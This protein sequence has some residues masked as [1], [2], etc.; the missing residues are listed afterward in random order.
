MFAVVILGGIGNVAGTLLAGL[1]VGALSGV[2]SVVWSPAA[3]PLVVFSAVI[4]ALLFRPQGSS[5]GGRADARPRAGWLCAVIAAGAGSRLPVIRD[6][7]SGCPVFYLVFLASVLFWVAQATS[8]NIL[9][10]YSGYFSFGQGAFFGVG[11]YTTAVLIGRHGS[12]SSLT[13]PV[14]GA[15]SALGLALVIGALAFRLRSLRGEIFALLTLAVPFILAPSS[16]SAPMP[17]TAGRGSSCRSRRSPTA[18]GGFQDFLYLL[19][20]GDRAAR[21]RRR[22]RRSSTLGIGWALFAIRDA[23]DVAEGLGV[24]TFRLQD[25]RHRRH[26]LHRRAGRCA[27]IALQIGLRHRRG[28]FGLTV[29]LFVIVM[30]VLGGRSHWAGPGDGGAS[31]C[32]RSRTGSGRRASRAGSDRPRRGPG[33]LVCCRARRG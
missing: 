18:L 12:T 16:A 15:C 30:S 33:R 5:R 11:A 2:V 32:S 23:E 7:A 9:S 24:P 27:C 25:A 8:W 13:L 4:L 21:R 6:S 22:L 31:S 17:S 20:A 26:R 29:P 14:A 1:L 10:G 3:A 19:S 28:V